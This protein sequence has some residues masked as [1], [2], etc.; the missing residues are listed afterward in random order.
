MRAFKETLAA[1]KYID[2]PSA[3]RIMRVRAGV[4]SAEEPA[5]LIA[6]E[7]T[8]GGLEGMKATRPFM[9]DELRYLDLMFLRDLRQASMQE[10]TSVRNLKIFNN[11]P[12]RVSVINED[13]IIVMKR[14]QASMDVGR[15]SLEVIS[16]ESYIGLPGTEV[17]RNVKPDLRKIGNAV[18][19]LL[20]IDITKYYRIA[21]T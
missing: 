12:Y 5:L 20:P 13:N 17:L 10:G 6:A 15:R 9:K 14:I 4:G 7:P 18:V 11:S 21:K 2:K 19:N 16:R 8:I 3:E 1:A